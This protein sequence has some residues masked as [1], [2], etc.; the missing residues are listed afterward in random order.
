M[1]GDHGVLRL[2]DGVAAGRLAGLLARAHLVL[3]GLG[4]L[5]DVAQV[6]PGVATHL[7]LRL[8]GHD[9]D[10]VVLHAVSAVGD[11]E[12]V[13]GRDTVVL[14]VVLGQLVAAELGRVGVA[15]PFLQA[16]ARDG[17]EV[18]GLGR[19]LGRLDDLLAGAAHADAHGLAVQR[20]VHLAV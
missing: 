12:A 5:G 6:A 7:E 10:V 16:P 4:P 1:D 3:A 13:A 11:V 20:D 9:L 18:A 17:D 19:E 14:G 2:L 8:L 15:R